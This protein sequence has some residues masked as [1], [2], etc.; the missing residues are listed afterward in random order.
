MVCGGVA[1]TDFGCGDYGLGD[2]CFGAFDGIKGREAAGEI[3]SDRR[4]EGT[5][6]TVCTAG[7]D[8]GAS[9]EMVVILS[10]HQVSCVAFEMPAFYYDTFRPKLQ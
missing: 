9:E 10:V 8:A 3:G 1:F 7:H 5:A 2:V 4:R 6:G